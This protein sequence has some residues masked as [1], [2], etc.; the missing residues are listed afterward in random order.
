MTACWWHLTRLGSLEVSLEH[1]AYGC[2]HVLC[3]EDGCSVLR[4][5][6]RPEAAASGRSNGLD[7]SPPHQPRRD[8][9]VASRGSA[10]CNSTA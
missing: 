4:S 6:P 5:M 8:R 1:S 2:H 3:R 9:S 7:G 10:P